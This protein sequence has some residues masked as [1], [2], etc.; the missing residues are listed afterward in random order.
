MID[1]AHR[2]S[3]HNLL[4]EQQVGKPYGVWRILVCCQLLNRTHGRQVRPMIES[5]FER[6]PTPFAVNLSP[7][8]DME[9]ALRPLG[10]Q[11][12]RARNLRAMSKQYTE[13]LYSDDRFWQ[14]HDN[15]LWCLT[16]AGCGQYAKESLNLVVYGVLD[17]PTTDSWLLRYRDWRI[18]LRDLR[19]KGLA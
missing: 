19:E 3:H 1:L 13:L 4:Q 12:Q 8:E 18:E 10:F 17:T 14:G 6:W 5:F 16:L 11:K 7:F 15:G 9:N 2:V